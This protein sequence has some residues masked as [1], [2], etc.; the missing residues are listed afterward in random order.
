MTSVSPAIPPSPALGWGAA[1]LDVLGRPAE[2]VRGGRVE[3][4]RMA[5]ASLLGAAG[6]AAFFAA[7]AVGGSGS[8]SPG[9]LLAPA[10]G[11]LLASPPL[12]LAAGLLGS[13]ARVADLVGL[14]AAGPVTAGL[15]LGAATP[16]LALYALSAPGVTAA[17]LA[18][19]LLRA[20]LVL[21]GMLAGLLGAE[22]AAEGLGDAAPSRWLVRLHE[23]FVFWTVA[24][25]AAHLG[26]A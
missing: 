2:L 25:L 6:A 16:I 11:V 15:A 20:G 24:A 12:V 19:E 3:P 17:A 10:L 21:A 18:F 13:S 14:A 22:R 9:L 8:A 5:A 26:S 1:I 4:R 7:G 23:L